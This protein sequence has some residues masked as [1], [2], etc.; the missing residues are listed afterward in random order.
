M[1]AWAE[2]HIWELV[3]IGVCVGVVWIGLV[4]WWIHHM[5]WKDRSNGKQ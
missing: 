3:G 2:Q 4:F 5:E 1:S